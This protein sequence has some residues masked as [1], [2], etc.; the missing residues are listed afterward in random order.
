VWTPRQHDWTEAVGTPYAE[1]VG[2]STAVAFTAR[3]TLY[4][5]AV[6]MVGYINRRL[7]TI[8]TGTTF[9]DRS[10]SPYFTREHFYPS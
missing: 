3:Y 1:D 9:A 2:L 7:L 8:E 10:Q 6:E 4:H 5:C